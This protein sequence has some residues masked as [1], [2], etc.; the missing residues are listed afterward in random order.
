MM[1][2]NG[3]RAPMSA[4]FVPWA[5]KGCA[6][7]LALLPSGLA[8]LDGGPVALTLQNGAETLELTLEDLK[9]LDQHT[10][11]TANEF[12]DGPVAY[13][14]PL[15]RDVLGLLGLDGVETV[16]FTAAN[17]YSIDVPTEDF[18]DYDAVLAMEADG[19]R[20][21][22]RDK[23]PLWLMYPLSENPELNGPVYNAR[24][25]WQVVRVEAL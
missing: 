17:D 6:V 15:A 11:V 10:V 25:I 1:L 13:T 5:I 4:A 14:G 12:T 20:L 24:L 9:E 23:G 18:R 7:A 22:R 19:E 2:V 3:D 16:R 8:A 21:S